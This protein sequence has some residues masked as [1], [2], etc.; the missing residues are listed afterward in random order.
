VDCASKTIER[1]ICPKIISPS[2]VS[3]KI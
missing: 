2:S 1:E 3:E